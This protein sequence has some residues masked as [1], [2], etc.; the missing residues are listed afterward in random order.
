MVA[1]CRKEA[2]AITDGPP[3]G[4]SNETKESSDVSAPKA[5][6]L[7]RTAEN[8]AAKAERPMAKIAA[9]HHETG[10]AARGD[11]GRRDGYVIDGDDVPTMPR[12]RRETPR[13]RRLIR[14]ISCPLQNPKYIYFLTTLQVRWAASGFIA[15]CPV[16][17]T[18][19]SSEFFSDF[20]V[21][22]GAKGAR[23][24]LQSNVDPESSELKRTSDAVWSCRW[25][26]S[27]VV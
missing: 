22:A 14:P 21:R 15:R 2:P 23:V 17:H 9:G 20:S 19:V 24:Q 4:P 11:Q 10:A 13:T 16:L 3:A 26:R 25:D 8:R 12:P 1:G 18:E 6:R 7:P 5:T 27:M